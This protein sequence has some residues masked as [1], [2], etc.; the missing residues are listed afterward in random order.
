MAAPSAAPG[1][2]SPVHVGALS[3]PEPTTGDPEPP[4]SDSLASQPSSKHS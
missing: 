2:G 3:A 4:W 1:V